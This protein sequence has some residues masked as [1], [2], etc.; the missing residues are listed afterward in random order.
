M[1]NPLRGAGLAAA[2]FAL[3][4]ASAPAADGHGAP[5]PPKYMTRLLHDCN[6]DY[7]QGDAVAAKDGHDLIALD[8]RE[9]FDK[10]LDRDVLIFRLVMNGGFGGN[11]NPTLKD[12]VRFSVGGATKTYR[13]TTTDNKAFSGTFDRIDGPAPSLTAEGTPDGQRFY[14][15]GVLTLATVGATAGQ[16]LEGYRV[17]SYVDAQVRDYMP[18]TYKTE[19]GADAPDAV[20]C[21][22]GGSQTKY[23]SGPYTIRGPIQYVKAVLEPGSMVLAPGTAQTG[24]VRVTNLVGDRPQDVVA[25]ALD[26][27]GIA[28]RFHSSS[29]DSYSPRFEGTVPKGGALDIHVELNSTSEGKTDAVPI[30]VTTNLGGRVVLSLAYRSEAAALSTP[31]ATTDPTTAAPMRTAG[32]GSLPSVAGWA[33]AAAALAYVITRRMR[34]DR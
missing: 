20:A 3:I 15:E 24:T 26:P 23:A 21:P 6:D 7:F 32:G 13:F 27:P 17:D 11:G 16:R 34:T 1:T 28:H 2:L 22:D 9:A 10:A 8:L 14:V 12:E 19:A 29:S 25:T 5:P 33:T 30:T 18:G 4:A 31:A